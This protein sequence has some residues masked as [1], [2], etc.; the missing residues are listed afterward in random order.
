M[1]TSNVPVEDVI[2]LAFT[3]NNTGMCKKGNLSGYSPTAVILYLKNYF[4]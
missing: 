3:K 2:S 4:L 1:H